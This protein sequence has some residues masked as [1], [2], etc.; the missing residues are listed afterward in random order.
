MAAPSEIDAIRERAILT[1]L[2][3][4]PFLPVFG[5][6]WITAGALSYWVPLTVAPWLYPGL[7]GLAMPIAIMLE[8]RL[9]YVRAVDPDPL[10]PLTLHLLFVQIVAF[11]AILLVWDT[12][13]ALM[14]VAFAA[15]VGAHFLPFQWVYR[16]SVYGVL[17]VVVAVGPFI[18]A[19]LV[20]QR[21]LH[22]TGLFVGCAL[23]AGAFLVRSHANATW[24]ASG[25]AAHPHQA[26]DGAAR[27]H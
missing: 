13:P 25:Q 8:R 24:I 3:G 2:A 23:L 1:S 27:G 10:L 11:P 16:T 7:G 18:L 9:G 21:A 26:G 19:L 4:F 20:G 6:V 15:V 14:P 17:A 5:V 22:L 12:T